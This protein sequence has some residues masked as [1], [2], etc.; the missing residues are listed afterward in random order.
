M[1]KRTRTK[2]Y[3]NPAPWAPDRV[4]RVRKTR[5][6]PETIQPMHIVRVERPR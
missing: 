3:H 5:E 2:D 1:K 6:A 4:A